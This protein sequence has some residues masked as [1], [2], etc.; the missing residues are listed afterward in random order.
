MNTEKVKL[1]LDRFDIILE[2]LGVL[3]VS[4]LIILPILHYNDL[5]ESIP[6]HFGDLLSKY[7]I[8]RVREG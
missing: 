4:L 3:G 8:L 1:N 6:R 5:P 7:E 2:I